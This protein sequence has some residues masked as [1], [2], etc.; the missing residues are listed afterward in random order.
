LEWFTGVFLVPLRLIPLGADIPF[1]DEI[2][3]KVIEEA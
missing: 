2:L 3:G 1:F